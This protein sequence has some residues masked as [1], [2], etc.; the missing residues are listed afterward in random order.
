[1]PAFLKSPKF[2][3]GAIIVLWVAYIIWANLHLEVQVKLI[4]FV[5]TLNFSVPSVIIAAAI[6]GVIVTLIVQ[7]LWK[8]RSSK[9]AAASSTA[10]AANAKTVA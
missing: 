2:I 3:I 5:A 4:P 1:M 9:D 7:W 6:F 10:S 8:R